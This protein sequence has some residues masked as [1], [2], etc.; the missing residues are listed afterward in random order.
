MDLRNG[1]RARSTSAWVWMPEGDVYIPEGVNIDIGP[2]SLLKG[3]LRIETVPKSRGTFADIPRFGP[4][5]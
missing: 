1:R 3:G 5:P 2:S 4:V